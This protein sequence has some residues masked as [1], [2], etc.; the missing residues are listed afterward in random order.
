MESNP[1]VLKSSI[2]GTKFNKYKFPVTS[3]EVQNNGSMSYGVHK[4]TRQFVSDARMDMTNHVC[5]LIMYN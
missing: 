5:I 1:P 2:H 3:Q 4:V